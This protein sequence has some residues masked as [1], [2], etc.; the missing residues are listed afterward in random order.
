[1]IRF[2]T[3]LQNRKTPKYVLLTIGIILTTIVILFVNKDSIIRHYAYKKI[4]SIRTQHQLNIGFSDLKTAG[5]NKLVIN[6]LYIVPQN[7]DTLLKAGDIKIKVSL[8]KLFG[9]NIDIRK[10][11][12]KHIQIDFTKSDSISNFDFIYYKRNNT[13]TQA[14]NSNFNYSK[15]L[16]QLFSLIFDLLPSNAQMEDIHVAYH[17]KNNH[18]ILSIT[19]FKIKD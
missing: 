9:T 7:Q 2:F 11:D 13:N 1:M 4:E 19:S 17:N 5:L 6:N 10:I 18:V 8:L 3:A 16:K 15:K 12:I 14:K